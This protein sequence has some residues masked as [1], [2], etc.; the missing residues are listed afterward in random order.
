MRN[1]V[2]SQPY[3]KL[4]RY[5]YISYVTWNKQ[6]EVVHVVNTYIYE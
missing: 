4:E 1:N 2:E 3:S 5:V 6:D